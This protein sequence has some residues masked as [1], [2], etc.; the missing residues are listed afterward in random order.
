MR[1]IDDAANKAN[2]E[3]ADRAGHERDGKPKKRAQ[4]CGGER[5]RTH[6]HQQTRKPIGPPARLSQGEKLSAEQTDEGGRSASSMQPLTPARSFA[7]SPPSPSRERVSRPQ[8]TGARFSQ[9]EK[10]SAE[11]TDEGSDLRRACSPSPRLGAL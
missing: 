6:V 11:Q 2:D 4:Q 8:P 9:G 10:L 3:R 1:A 7:P 5:R